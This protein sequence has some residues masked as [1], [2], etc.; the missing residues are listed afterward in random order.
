MPALKI[1]GTILIV[2]GLFLAYVTYRQARYNQN[3][4]DWLLTCMAIVCILV[5]MGLSV[6][7][8]CFSPLL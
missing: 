8:M 1:V 4:L 2:F 6:Y 5:L 3:V 7:L